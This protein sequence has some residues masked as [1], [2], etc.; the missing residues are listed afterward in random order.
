MIEAVIVHIVKDGRILL[1]YKKR[2][3]GAGFWNGVGGK[4]EPGETPEQC[5]IRESIE[6]MNANVKNLQ[7]IGELKF[8][9]VTDEDWMVHVFRAEID[10]EPQESEESKPEWFSMD[11]IPYDEMWEDDRYWLPLVINGI[12]FRAE[13]WF[14]GKEM[15]RFKMEA[16]KE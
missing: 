10:G 2:G 1:H 13:F 3:H 11:E 14:S 7:K 15:L 5:A 4:I 16:W 8:Y 6:E 9:D 12:R